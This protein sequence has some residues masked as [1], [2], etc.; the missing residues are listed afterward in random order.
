[1]SEPNP[2]ML[3]HIA[4]VERSRLP[5]SSLPTRGFLPD[6]GARVYAELGAHVAFAPR[7]P[8]E[9]DPS[10]K[11][12]I[13][14]IVLGDAERVFVT[15]RT[16]AQTEARLHDKMSFGVGGHLETVDGG[17]DDLVHAGAVRELLEELAVPEALAAQLVYQGVINDDSNEVGS[18]HLGVV[19]SLHVPADADVSV[20]EV[21]KMVGAWMTHDEVRAHAPRLES[22]SAMLLDALGAFFAPER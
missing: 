15:R 12:L 17:A 4:Y 11:Q 16:R 7:G 14:Y 6:P 8:L 18:V 5:A 21:D 19:Y 3:A 1:M 9:E 22:W 2:A 20:R 13:P 10:R